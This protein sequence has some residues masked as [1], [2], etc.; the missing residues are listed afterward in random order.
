MTTL[1]GIKKRLSN[2]SIRYTLSFRAA[3]DTTFSN[4]L[5]LHPIFPVPIISEYK[6]ISM[7][8]FVLN[9]SKDK[10]EKYV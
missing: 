10:D 4:L 6:E 7:N 8:I 1:N 9:I 2:S 3:S 5:H